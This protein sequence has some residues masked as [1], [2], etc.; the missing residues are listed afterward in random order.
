MSS[1]TPLYARRR[2]AKSRMTSM[3]A[4]G[5]RLR[6]SSRWRCRITAIVLSVT[7]T[8]SAGR[9]P[10]SNTGI[11]ENVRPGPK[12]FRTCSRPSTDVVTVRT[13]PL[14]TMKSPWHGS[15]F[16]KI[17]WP[18]PVHCQCEVGDT[19]ARLF[20]RLAR[21]VVARLRV[22]EDVEYVL[23]AIRPPTPQKR[24]WSASSRVPPRRTVTNL[25]SGSQ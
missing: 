4:S 14:R 24:R 15:P 10:L 20:D 11:S 21:T 8:A 5:W 23:R 19:Q 13:R 2:D 16:E 22:L 6:R 9:G 12:T 3:Q 7:A 1:T 25:V 18:A 17:T